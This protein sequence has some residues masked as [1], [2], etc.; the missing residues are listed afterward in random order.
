[1]RRGRRRPGTVSRDAPGMPGPCRRRTSPSP[2]TSSRSRAPLARRRAR[3]SVGRRSAEPAETVRAAEKENETRS[4]LLLHKK[5][6]APPSYGPPQPP[7]GHGHPPHTPPERHD[8]PE[9]RRFLPFLPH[10]AHQTLPPRRRARR[11]RRA[12]GGV[13]APPHPSAAAV[14]TSQRLSSTISAPG[15]PGRA[16]RRPAPVRP[17][18]ASTIAGSCPGFSTGVAPSP[19]RSRR[20][21][22]S[23]GMGIARRTPAANVAGWSKYQR[24]ICSKLTPAGMDCAR[25]SWHMRAYRSWYAL[26]AATPP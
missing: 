21:Q 8:L 24:T 11:A 10:L 18:R 1:M 23:P 17:Q 12:G 26:I 4:R 22:N 13:V 19:R 6:P 16:F 2:P 20:N 9:P 14:H 7:L 15:A 25:P 5:S 3:K